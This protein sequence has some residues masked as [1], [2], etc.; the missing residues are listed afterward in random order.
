M[1]LLSVCPSAQ[2][3]DCDCSLTWGGPE[4][5]QTVPSQQQSCGLLLFTQW[6][7]SRPDSAQ[8]QHVRVHAFLPHLRQLQ[9]EHKAQYPASSQ[10]RN[11]SG[12]ANRKE[13][14][15]AKH[16]FGKER[17]GPT[18]YRLLKF[19]SVESNS[20]QGSQQCRWDWWENSYGE[21]I[22]LMKQCLTSDRIKN[23]WPLKFHLFWNFVI[24]LQMWCKFKYFVIKLKYIWDKHIRTSK[25]VNRSFFPSVPHHQL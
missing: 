13:W 7:S 18:L 24:S 20:L 14:S 23:V 15:L 16:K 5:S 25:S 19:L 11:K 17:S 4:E 22:W 12:N 8:A 1:P 6:A 10:F 3:R 9:T 2:D 21:H